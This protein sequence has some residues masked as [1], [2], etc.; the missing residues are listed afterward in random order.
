[1][2]LKQYA[3]ND[4]GDWYRTSDGV[5]L[6]PDDP[7]MEPINVLL[8]ANQ[9]IRDLRDERDRLKLNVKETDQPEKPE[10]EQCPPDIAAALVQVLSKVERL[11][12]S[13]YNRHF[14]YHFAT[15]SDIA[16]LIRPAMAEAGLTLV[17]DEHE[18]SFLGQNKQVVSIA[19]DFAFLHTSGARW[20][21]HH[22]FT[23]R[24]LS[25]AMD[26]QGRWDDK[27]FP[28]CRTMA[29]KE[30]VKA[31]FQ[32]S[33]GDPTEDSDYDDGPAKQQAATKASKPETQQQKDAQQKPAGSAPTEQS[34]IDAAG[35]LKEHIIN[36]TNPEHLKGEYL[37]SKFLPQLQIL[38]DHRRDL[39][40]ETDER[41]KAK[42]MSLREQAAAGGITDEDDESSP[43]DD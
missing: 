40:K 36:C 19:Y 18:P 9:L 4:D 10:R 25:R 43:F 42:I 7:Q 41:R 23:I 35:V 2:K 21:S 13:G 28:K 12:K 27:C 31:Q 22:P 32:I 6:N 39:W 14:G 37:N 15:E 8:A 26:N 33:A 29:R 16:D 20:P 30:F 5:V 17:I 3:R 34:I 11:K 1:M 24:G 38:Y